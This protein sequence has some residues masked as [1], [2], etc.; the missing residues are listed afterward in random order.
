MVLLHRFTGLALC[1]LSGLTAASA[2]K[3]QARAEP[4]VECPAEDGMNVIATDSGRTFNVLCNHDYDNYTAFQ[5]LGD[6]YESTQTVCLQTCDDSAQCDVYSVIPNA[7]SA[8][9]V[10]CFYS[11]YVAGADQTYK[12]DT[13]G[14]NIIRAVYSSSSASSSSSGIR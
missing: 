10:R 8:G 11:H 4:S 5:N 3:L 12:A 14:V 1:S 13:N 7:N 9:D 2:H 6:S